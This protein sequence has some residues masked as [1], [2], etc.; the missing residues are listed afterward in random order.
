MSIKIIGT[1]VGPLLFFLILLAPTP[2]GLSE[3]G[4][5]VL[6]IASWMIV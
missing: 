4:K 1:I 6:A 3:E 2:T 5:I